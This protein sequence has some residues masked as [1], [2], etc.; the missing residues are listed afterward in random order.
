MTSERTPRYIECATNELRKQRRRNLSFSNPHIFGDPAWELLL[1]AY[2]AANKGHCIVPSDLGKDLRRP[3]SV[4]KRLSSILET[5]G[6]IE[7]CRLHRC[8]GLGCFQ[9]TDDAT[10]WCEQC[11]A[12][13]GFQNN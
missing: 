7:G 10:I 5:E 8:E 9:L 1:E 2:I 13:D 12:P 6:Y 4:V 11:L 3:V